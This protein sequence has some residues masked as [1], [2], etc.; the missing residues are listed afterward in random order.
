[1]EG[2]LREVG[3]CVSVAPGLHGNTGEPIGEVV[4]NGSNLQRRGIETGMV[5]HYLHSFRHRLLHRIGMMHTVELLTPL[6]YLS[7]KIDFDGTNIIAGTTERA[8]RAITIVLVA[9]AEHTEID[10]YGARNEIRIRVTSR[11]AIYRTCVHAGT[12]THALQ[13]LPMIFIAQN[14]TAAIVYENDVHLGAG[15]GFAE[16][17]GIYSGR[18]TCAVSCEKTLEYGHGLIVWDELFDSHRYDMQGRN[19]SAHIGIS[20]IGAY[21]DLA[22]LCDSEVGACHAA[23]GRHE[24]VAEMIAS[25]T[26]QESRIGLGYKSLEIAMHAVGGLLTFLID[27]SMATETLEHLLAGDM[28]SWHD[29]MAWRNSE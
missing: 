5:E 11:A 19:G 25:A 4:G 22:G 18:L 1:M 8:G 23:I 29:D 24:I 7:G 2:F 14:F 13:R 26:G 9:V 15:T 17:G 28:N 3:H 20:F 12:A 27:Y 6:V 10:T 21:H 16:V